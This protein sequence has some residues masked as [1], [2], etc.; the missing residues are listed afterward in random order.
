VDVSGSELIYRD[1]LKRASRPLTNVEAH[2]GALGGGAPVPARI[3]FRIRQ[4]RRAA[5][6]EPRRD[7]AR[8]DAR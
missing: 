2:A 8:C 4:W 1:E 3:E 7:S 5:G 6:S